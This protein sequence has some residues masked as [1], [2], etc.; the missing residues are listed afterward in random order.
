MVNELDADGLSPLYLA[1]ENGLFDLAEHLLKLGADANLLLG[2]PGEKRPTG[3]V[4]FENRSFQS[5][6]FLIEHGMQVSWTYR[7]FLQRN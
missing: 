6:R 4:A 3:L 5:V 1:L 7:T 2:G